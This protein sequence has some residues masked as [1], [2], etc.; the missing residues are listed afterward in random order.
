MKN[1]DVY[2]NMLEIYIQSKHKYIILCN[3]SRSFYIQVINTLVYL[4]NNTINTAL[5]RVNTTVNLLVKINRSQD[6]SVVHQL[7]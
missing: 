4:T 2:C 1:A 5:V 6:R 3:C 7:L